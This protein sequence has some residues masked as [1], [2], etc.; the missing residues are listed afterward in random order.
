MREEAEK[1]TGGGGGDGA[2]DGDALLLAA[3]KLP[4]AATADVT[5]AP[6]SSVGKSRRYI[7]LTGFPFPLGP[8]V[9]RPT[10]ATTIVPGKVYSFEQEQ[11]LSGIP[12]NV[13]ATVFRMRDNLVLVR[14]GTQ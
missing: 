1:A 10:V 11:A 2:G 6:S 14:G 4:A 7:N 12:A 9:E 5:D 3:R 13:R 8:F